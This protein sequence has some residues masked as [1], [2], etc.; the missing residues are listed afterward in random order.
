MSIPASASD[1]AMVEHAPY[2]PKYGEPV[3][4]MA[5]AVLTHWFKRSP[6]MMISSASAAAPALLQASVNAWRIMWLSAA[7]QL[8]SPKYE[9]AET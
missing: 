8:F 5:N 1:S 7:S 2:T 9:S 3:S 6:E 4:F